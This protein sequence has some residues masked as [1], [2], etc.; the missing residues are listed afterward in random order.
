MVYG[1]DA[2]RAQKDV[3]ARVA[4]L[5]GP[6]RMPAQFRPALTDLPYPTRREERISVK[7]VR[8]ATREK[9]AK[10]K[11]DAAARAEHTSGLDTTTAGSAS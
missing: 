6:L 10:A 4:V 2:V 8:A 3:N 9:A 11:A 7:R 1:V 5:E